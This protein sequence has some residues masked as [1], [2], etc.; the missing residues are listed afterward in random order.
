MNRAT[1]IASFPAVEIPKIKQKF[2]NADHPHKFINS[3]I[4]DFQE[5]S[6]ENDDY[7]IPSGFFDVPKKVV[8]VDIPYCLKNKEFSKRFMKKFDVFTDTIFALCGSL[9]KLSICLNQRVEISI[10]HV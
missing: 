4:N 2:L 9:R 5:K 8:L 3:V 1:P 7:I 10:H 6:D